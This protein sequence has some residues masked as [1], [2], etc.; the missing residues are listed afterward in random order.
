MLMDREM[1]MMKIGSFPP[2]LRRWQIQ[3][4]LVFARIGQGYL[5][6]TTL[7]TPRNLAVT[8]YASTPRELSFS[9]REPRIIKSYSGSY[10]RMNQPHGGIW[11]NAWR[12]RSNRRDVHGR[13][14]L[15]HLLGSELFVSR[16]PTLPRR[17]KAL[18]KFSTK[19]C[20]ARCLSVD[21][22]HAY[23]L[24]AFSASCKA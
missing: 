19:Y 24:V 6:M 3:F 21:L 1:P 9:S 13:N 20:P 11:Q 14:G 5:V 4:P 23:D 16:L 22:G 18:Y 10:G 12:K 7:D 17:V 2:W 15:P 8:R